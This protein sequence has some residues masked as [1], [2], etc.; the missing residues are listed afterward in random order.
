M[1]STPELVLAAQ[2]GETAAFAELVRLYERTAVVTAH[3]VLGDFHAAQDAAQ[4]GLVTAYRKLGQLRDRDS[5]GP[6]M[7]QI[8]RRRAG[9]IRAR[10]QPPLDLKSAIEAPGDQRHELDTYQEVMQTISRLPEHERVVVVLHYI[11]GH[12]V[13]DVARLTGRPV[14]TVTKQLS[15]AIGRLKTWL[16]EVQS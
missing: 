3:A 6:W 5:F 10:T 16:I 4:D 9:E 8:V 14:G 2:A 15:R 1:R 13:T 11:D 7:L 12:S